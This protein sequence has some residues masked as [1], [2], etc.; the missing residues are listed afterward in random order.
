MAD[1]SHAPFAAMLQSRAVLNVSGPDARS[2]LQ[3]LVT[4]D[5]NRV[6]RERALYAALLTPQGKFLFDFFIVED[7]GFWLD[8][9]ADRA[10]DLKKRLTMYKLRA[11]VKIS[12]EADLA[13]AAV[14][15]AA[16]P[17]LPAQAEPGQAWPVCGGVAFADPRLIELGFRLIAPRIQLEA[18]IAAAGV[19]VADEAAYDRHRLA[20]GIPEGGVDIE[21]DK[22][23]LLESNFDELHG[24]DF[25]KGCYVGQELTARTKHRG[26]IRKRLIP[27]NVSGPLPAPGTPVTAGEVT[28]GE[29]RS[30]R[31]GRAL[32]LIRLDRYETARTSGERLTAGEAGLT[33][34]PPEWLKPV[35]AAASTSE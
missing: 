19:P 34:D 27:V 29:V 18:D 25:R 2:F 3:G 23:F 31:G 9:A 13:I 17:G 5:M 10:A 8:C 16:P 33:L 11:D 35:L 15:G 21:P 26:T 14:A 12:D 7:D 6:S 30:G 32:A 1:Q 20:L 28:L 22:S 24:V 4:N